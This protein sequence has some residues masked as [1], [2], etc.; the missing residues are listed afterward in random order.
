MN[1]A[2]PDWEDH[3]ATINARCTEVLASPEFAAVPEIAATLGMALPQLRELV[4]CAARQGLPLAL[5]EPLAKACDKRGITQDSHVLQRFLL[6]AS[7]I[8]NLR[9]VPQLPVPDEVKERLFDQFSYVCAPDREIE[10]LLNPRHYGFRVM[11]K[12]M[13]LERFPAGQSDWEISG[14]PRS[15][16]V[17]MPFRDVPKTLRCVFLRAGGRWPFFE[18][19]TAFRRDL[20]IITEEEERKVFRLMAGAMKLQPAI[21]GYM[22]SAWFMDPSL[23]VVSPHLAW[24]ADWWRECVDFGAVWTNTGEA[25]PDSGF[26]VGDRH[27]RRLYQSGQWK[28]RMGLI[29]WER[30]DLLRWFD[31]Q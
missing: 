29:V 10:W 12:F 27:R 3:L 2:V 18:T 20:P 11:C 30:S 15:Y 6:L 13:L 26:L 9:L 8:A 7:G 23:A 31:H 17:K 25:L 24:L 5:W 4:V 28:P 16:L 1:G 21:R 19:H 22:G 14:F